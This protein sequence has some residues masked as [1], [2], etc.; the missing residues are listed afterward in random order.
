MTSPRAAAWRAFWQARA[1]RERLLI[2]VAIAAVAVLL[3]WTVALQPALRTLRTAPAQIDALDTQLQD[4]Q[5][6][7]GEV[8]E[9]RATPPVT[10]EQ[11]VAAARASVE[12]LGAK[13]RLV[14]QGDR[15]VVTL[16]TVP[17]AAL[18]EFLLELRQGARARPLE[19]TLTRTAQG[20][21]G[22]LVLALPG[23]AR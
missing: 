17:T 15:L 2:S 22:T 16:D 1:P 21:S 23:A 19:A 8:R 11:S 6:L 7:A 12:R 9:L 13:A 4:M 10:A 3:L 18:R 5:R 20:F 14:Q